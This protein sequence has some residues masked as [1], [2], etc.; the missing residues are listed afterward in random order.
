MEPS[1]SWGPFCYTDPKESKWQPSKSSELEWTAILQ[2]GPNLSSNKHL[3]YTCVYIE[4]KSFKMLS[5]KTDNVT[6]I[7]VNLTKPRW[8]EGS[9]GWGEL[10]EW[11][12]QIQIATS[13][14][15]HDVTKCNLVF[16]SCRA[17]FKH[18]SLK[19]EKTQ[20]QLCRN[21]HIMFSRITCLIK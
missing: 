10:S 8:G 13:W 6:V 4:E 2:Q 9:N 1:K 3:W 15:D 17:K 7:K 18:L 11:G 5:L 14:K 20:E 12:V 19:M 21:E 16:P